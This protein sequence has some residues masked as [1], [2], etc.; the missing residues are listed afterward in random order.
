MSLG[1][2]SSGVDL[3][4]FRLRI[5]RST[6]WSQLKTE[7]FIWN[8]AQFL[9]WIHL[10]SSTME[11]YK[12]HFFTL[13][14]L[15][16]TIAYPR[17][18]NVASTNVLITFIGHGVSKQWLHHLV[19]WRNTITEVRAFRGCIIVLMCPN[20]FQATQ[21]KLNAHS[22]RDTRYIATYM[23]F[24]FNAPTSCNKLFTY[25]TFELW[26]MLYELTCVIYAFEHD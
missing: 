15:W 20:S 22:F 4:S 13:A 5:I 10:F 1:I 18:M 26:L 8:L 19:L 24:L 14:L 6:W 17:W 7:I 9:Q 25:L 12:N 21:I 23:I 16:S 2:I 11:R 3:D